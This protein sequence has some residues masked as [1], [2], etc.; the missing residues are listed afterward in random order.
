MNGVPGSDGNA[1][2]IAVER[3]LEEAEIW[4]ARLLGEAQG[5]REAFERWLA[6]APAHRE[7]WARTQ[8]L[9]QGVGAALR[10]PELSGYVEESLAR[11]EKAD[12][13]EAIAGW[14]R[15]RQQGNRARRRRTR[16]RRYLAATAAV[17]TLSLLGATGWLVGRGHVERYAADG[18]VR[19]VLLADG[20]RVELDVDARIQVRIGWW[21]RLVQLEQGRVLFD[22]VRDPNRPFIVDGGDSRITVLGT[23][24]QA[25]RHG[26]ALDV[27]LERGAVALR[28]RSE[29]RSVL[30]EPGQ[31]A[32]WHSQQAGWALAKVNIDTE[33]SWAR[34]FHVFDLTALDQA[35]DEINRYSSGA[36]IR[37]AE[38]ELARLRLSGSFRAG[39]AAGIA[40]VL[41]YS[42]PIVVEQRGDQILL[43]SK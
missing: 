33:T 14:Q 7:A 3:A 21:R 36:K 25:K 22:V 5:D 29:D 20:T 27:M 26:D 9:W 35:I 30:L 32:R 11:D 38:P 6:A 37:L 16:G 8:S 2:D 39:D 40:E 31:Q 18:S 42:L 34:G 1:G 17:A 41:P 12:P 10:S 19:E 28:S 13:V 24:F 23:R 15:A 43:H 4:F